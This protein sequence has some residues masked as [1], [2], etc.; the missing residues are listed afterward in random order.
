MMND[1]ALT[2]NVAHTHVS[3]ECGGKPCN[4]ARTVDD[5]I[6]TIE[7]SILI[8]RKYN[9]ADN[10]FRMMAV[11]VGYWLRHRKGMTL[12]TLSK[13][14]YSNDSGYAYKYTHDCK[15]AL[16][17]KGLVEHVGKTVNG[18]DVYAPTVLLLIE[19][20]ELCNVD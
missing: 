16:V 8:K 1:V 2:E 15:S 19:F 13:S 9:I 4:A 12:H 6:R 18:F 5:I 20:E 17:K 10:V 3:V 7:L 11:M 14:I